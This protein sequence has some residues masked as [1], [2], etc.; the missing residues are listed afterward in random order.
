[1]QLEFTKLQGL[2]NDYLYFDAQS[3]NPVNPDW[4]RV[5][6]S[7]CDRHFG[8]GADG[9]I[10][11]LPSTHAVTRMRIWNADGSEAE[12]CG[13]GFRGVVKWLYDR[14]T[15][16]FSRGIETG[17]G[18]LMPEVIAAEGGLVRQVRVMMGVPDFTRR[19]VGIDDSSD[20]FLEKT[21]RM[22]DIT[23]N[24]S[25]VS[26]GNPHLVI[27]GD[28]WSVDHM[29]LWG[30]LLEHHPWFPHRVNVHSMAIGSPNTLH[31]LHWERGAGLTLACGTGA[32]GAAAVALRLGHVKSPV[33]VQVP[34]GCLDV[35][36]AGPGS[37]LYLTGP[38][39][40]VFSGVVSWDPTRR[41]PVR[42]EANPN[43]V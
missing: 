21:L 18:L 24:V 16:D 12:M 30:P 40:E 8:V 37:P 20:E 19:A 39:E 28:L 14:G 15:R 42:K 27:I 38:S 31:L 13:N 23:L 6:Q 43:G 22:D 3:G 1:M 29:A 9:I 11:L 5:A 26:M 36:W 35:E 10:V 25:A 32:A 41:L 34:G 4:P 2:G 33:Q 17:A 7:L